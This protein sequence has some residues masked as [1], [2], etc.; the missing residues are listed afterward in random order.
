MGNAVY[1][2][3][4]VVNLLPMR[5]LAGLLSALGLVLAPANLWA[6][7][8]GLNVI[9]VV[10]QNS[11][12]SVQLGN[13]YCEQRGVPPQNL[14]RMT[15]WTGGAVEWSR[16]DFETLL[17]Q[18]LLGMITARGLTNQAEFV[19]LS[20]D[21]PY[22][23]ADNDS[24]ASHN[25]TTSALYYGFK[26]D[27]APPRC[28]PASCSLPVAS[29]N[30]YAFSE[31][32]FPEAP[33]DTAPT[34]S[35]LAM[36]LTA[37]NLDTANLI[38]SRG[39][40]SDSTFPTQ[41]VYLEQTSDPAR[42]V[43]FAQ[44]DNAIMD[45][46]ICGDSSL[47]WIVSDSTSYTNVL[48]LLTGLANLSIPG[49]AFVAGAIGDS[50]TSYAGE[51]FE[52]SSQTSLLVFL[53]AGASGSYGTIWEPC[54]YTQKFPDPLDYFYQD[55]GFC[56]AEAYYQSVLNPY[57]GLMA[58]EP[59]SAPFAHRGAADWST[60]ANGAIL[61]GVATLSPSF[62]A[63]V[64]NLPLGRVDLF[65]DGTFVQTIT[66]LP[67]SAGNSMAV[68]LNGL[69]VNYTVPANATVAS[70]TTGLAAALNAQTNSTQVEAFAIGDRIE[71]QSLN[72]AVP[73]SGVTM[74]AASAIGSAPQLTTWL[75]PA[76]PSFLDTS[77]T[78]YVAVL[79]SNAPAAGDWV[80]LAFTKT[81][82]TQVTV[83]ATNTTA[84]TTVAALTQSLVN[85]VNAALALQGPDG[86]LASDFADDTY[87]GIVAAQFTLY[88]RSPGWAASQIQVTLTASTNLLVLPSGT[89]GL[90]DN[91]NDLRPR[92]HLYV[93]SGA[94]SLPV[95]F[96]FDTTQF[97]DGWHQL[98][99]VAY[100]G[101]SVRTQTPV[102]RNVQIQNSPLSATFTALLAG[103]N[104][105]L[106]T[107]LQ[108]SVTA[109]ENNI[110]RIELFS[111]GGC[112]GVVSNQS[113]AVFTAPSA[114]L[115][116][117]LHPFYALVTDTAGH[118]YQT[119]TVWIRLVPS[120]T[121]SISRSPL[122][123]SW[124]AIPGQRYNVLAATNITGTFQSV[125]TV[126]ANSTSAQWPISAP[127][128]AAAF[129]RVQIS[130]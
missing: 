76:R 16:T 15:N 111:T 101:T 112:V 97:A 120:F 73:G 89:Y 56:L 26:D 96:Q 8:S 41:T 50:L 34:N 65:V 63:A 95:G 51:L 52:D 80:Q 19:L 124:T 72:V 105:T 30:S 91:I 18:P 77:A 11:T 24:L 81:N 46:R 128:G 55:R 79:V 27:V 6:G 61:K 99:A 54:N 121:I 25:G 108:F 115:G 40:A 130:P 106:S 118:R 78:G 116:L 98:T 70:V 9:V 14:L 33:P 2:A 67:P 84:G 88:A 10:N 36:M 29:S 82:G 31:L 37:S 13:N 113:T 43:R 104:A 49:N 3:R 22:R 109:S 94:V 127:G 53:N 62:A 59:L 47:V 110:S 125:A 123:L 32:P 39:V 129:Y 107:P 4:A 58:G 92:N 102:S 7:G 57:Q 45:S 90:Q 103:T 71:L 5:S 64:T 100:E 60:L 66:N 17:L 68:T 69:G 86:V 126:T 122:T 48:G 85:S 1:S 119:Q 87:C 114:M 35:F 12:N 117:G 75:T 21:I 44:F 23:I 74:S 28:L 93:S 83:G 20:M 38:L 42:N